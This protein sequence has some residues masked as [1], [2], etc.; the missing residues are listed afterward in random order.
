MA[1]DAHSRKNMTGVEVPMI[2]KIHRGLILGGGGVTGLAWEIGVLQ[3]LL[4]KGIDLRNADA[5]IGT[6]AGAFAASALMDERG[7]GF[8]YERQRTAQVQEISAVFT[9]DIIQQFKTILTACVDDEKEAGRRMGAFAAQA[10]TIDTAT[11][12][13]VVRDRLDRADWP[14]ERLRL[15]AVD[16]DTG[17]LHLLDQASGI[18]FVDAVSASGAAPGVWPVVEAGGKRW[19][20]GGSV[21]VTNAHL[22]QQFRRCLVISPMTMN[23]SGISVQ[24][25][26]DGFSDTTTALLVTPDESSVTAIGDNPLDPDRRRLAAEAGRDQGDRIAQ[27][28][29]AVWQADPECKPT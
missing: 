18:N 21:S 7:I 1:I 8:A 23:F 22:A 14:S 2:A 9:A 20:D 27:R 3:G 19:I 4:V 16:A 17:I 5:I 28:V 24:A 6:S 12:L 13:A 15:T 25:Q 26:L 11:R 10:A 29:A